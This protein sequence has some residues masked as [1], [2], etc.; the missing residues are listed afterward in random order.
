HP[1]LGLPLAHI[2]GPSRADMF[3]TQS[4][5]N[6]VIPDAIGGL[7]HL[8]ELFLTANDLV[9]L[10]DTIGLLSNLKIL[11]VS[12]NRLRALPDSISKCRS[13]VELN[14]SYNGLTYLPTNIGYDL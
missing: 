10:P 4:T 5:H 11:N 9:S 1:V 3:R 2:S 14:V 8:E 7:G 6:Q 12:S 13:L